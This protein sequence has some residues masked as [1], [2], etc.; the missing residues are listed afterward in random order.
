MSHLQLLVADSSGNK[1]SSYWHIGTLE[2]D[3]E[4]LHES[5]CPKL[6]VSSKYSHWDPPFEF[7]LLNNRKLLPY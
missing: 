2:E 1:E 7:V 6:P 4:S 3:A 5:C